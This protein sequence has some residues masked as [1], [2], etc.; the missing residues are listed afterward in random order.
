MDEFMEEEIDLRDYLWVMYKR[1]WTIISIATIAVALGIVY[2]LTSI[3][4]FRATTQILI[5][6]ENPN[7]VDFK[8]LYAVD[9]TTQDFYQ[10]QYKI[11][12]SKLLATKVIDKLNLRNNTTFNPRLEQKGSH[13]SGSIFSFHKNRI[14]R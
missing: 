2:T 5:E 12:E 14:L 3:P 10:T 4:I 7:I 13:I 1:R 9:A 6:K 8:E 11:L